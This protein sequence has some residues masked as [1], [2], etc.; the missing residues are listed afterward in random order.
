M[1]RKLRNWWHILVDWRDFLPLKD[2]EYVVHSWGFEDGVLALTNHRLVHLIGD[3]IF[4]TRHY[5][6]KKDI[7]LESIKGIE[8]KGGFLTPN[9][10]IYTNEGKHSFKGILTLEKPK[11]KSIAEHFKEKVMEQMKERKQE[12]ERKKIPVVID[13]SFLK[14]Y[15]E[16]G[17]IV[18]TTLKC[19]HCSAPIKM[20]KGGAETL[21]EHCGST[22]YAQDIFEKVKKLIE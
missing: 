6:V 10:I 9:I 2:G 5:E 3:R 11:N 12:L 4:R 18:L 19:P 22:V 1:K 17:G 8:R 21:C 7:L 20:P 16:K 15:I 14:T 13:F